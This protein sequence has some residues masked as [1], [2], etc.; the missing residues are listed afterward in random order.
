MS[1]IDPTDLT[2][3]NR[4][5]VDYRTPVTMSTVQDT[6]LLLVNRGGVDYKCTFADWK[7][8]YV[9]PASIN[10]PSIT[11]PADGATGLGE[12]PTFTSSA[13]SGTGITHGSSDWQV[14]LATDT[15]FASPVV[16]SMTDT[17]NLVSWQGGPLQPDTD[18]IVRVRH[19]GGG[20]SSPWSDVVAFKT[21]AVFVPVATPGWFYR[22]TSEAD[23]PTQIS[24]PAKVVNMTSSDSYDKLYTVGV[25]GRIYSGTV[26]ATSL[27]ADPVFNV[28]GPYAQIWAAYSGGR[29]RICGLLADGRVVVGSST[30]LDGVFSA[31]GG[32]AIKSFSPIG[33]VGN[34]LIMLGASG[35][36]YGLGI[37]G[38][39][40]GT[41]TLTTEA[42]IELISITMPAGVKIKSVCGITGDYDAQMIAILGDNKKLY[43]S[44]SYPTVSKGELGFP[45]TGTNANPVDA[46]PSINN[47]DWAEIGV[48]SSCYQAENCFSALTTSGDLYA[49]SANGNLNLGGAH[50]FQ[51]IG[52]G[53]RST[54]VGAY[55]YKSWFALKND[56]KIYGAT[57]ST[58]PVAANLGTIVPGAWTSLGNMPGSCNHYNKPI[59]VIIPD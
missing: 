4:A 25:D 53:F 15:A 24:T 17:T 54:I 3:I 22:Y 51:L 39:K 19:N 20:M 2:V 26:S 45:N 43:F 59:Y 58:A 29:Y 44:G 10:K 34:L 13:F 57:S 7:A 18:Y 35:D 8:A 1:T 16:Q 40:V 42:T 14:T 41:H 56:G 31:P 12:T 5:G 9:P 49:A 50:S 47:K 52:S 55:G 6:D 38:H 32:E 46:G 27:S 30:V 21:K 33:G 36:V 28:H 48:G 11:S 37:P 23:V